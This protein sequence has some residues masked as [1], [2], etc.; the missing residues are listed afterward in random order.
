MSLPHKYHPGRLYILILLSALLLRADYDKVHD[1]LRV[2]ITTNGNN[3]YTALSNYGSL[4]EPGNRISDMVW[5]GLGYAYE[6]NM[7]VG[8]EVEVP[9]GSHPDAYEDNG[10]WKAHVFSDGVKGNGGEISP[11]GTMRWGWQPINAT[12]DGNLTLFD[13]ENPDIPRRHAYDIDGDGQTDSWPLAWESWPTLWPG[14]T[15]DLGQEYLYAM[16]D[17]DN[18]EFEYYP[19]EEDSTRRGLGVQV[20]CRTLVY[21]MDETADALVVIYDISNIS[22]RNLSRVQ[23]ALWG[24]PHIGG[25]DDWRD[26][27]IEYDAENDA[28]IVWD[29]DGHSVNSPNIIPGFMGIVFLET[30]GNA[31]DGTDNDGDGMTDESRFDGI[32]NDNDWNALYDDVGADGMEETG[33]AGESDGQPTPGEPHFDATD[34]DEGDM[35]GIQSMP[36]ISFTNIRASQDEKMWQELQPGNIES[37][38][39]PGDFVLLAGSGYFSLDAGQTKRLTAAFVFGSSREILLQKIRDLRAFY[40]R[41]IGNYLGQHSF[42]LQLEGSYPLY[43]DAI[44]LTWNI[45]E[46]AGADSL[47]LYYTTDNGKTW[48]RYPRKLYNN[49]AYTVDTEPLPSSVFYRFRLESVDGPYLYRA[50]TDSFFTVDNA[51]DENAYPEILWDL[52]DGSLLSGMDT[53]RWLDGDADGDALTRRVIIQSVLITDTLTATNHY[54]PLNTRQYPNDTYTITVK[55]SDGTAAAS[56]SRVV[57]FN[58]TFENVD[59][60]YVEHIRGPSESALWARI[61]DRSAIKKGLYLLSFDRTD[62]QTTYYSVYDSSR[63]YYL[64][65]NDPLPISP[66]SGRFFDGLS[67]S[68]ENKVYQVN[69][70]RS[71]WSENAATNLQPSLRKQ[72]DYKSLF[73]D[74][75]FLFGTGFADT[76]IN[77]INA[78]FSIRDTYSH[79]FM[80]FYMVDANNNGQWDPTETV[81]ILYGGVTIKD[82]LWEVSFYTPEGEESQ[83]PADGA[84]YTVAVD[85]P[86]S[87]EDRYIIDTNVLNL[88][89][90]SNAPG[91]FELRQNYP[92]PFN[93]STTLV[94][95]LQRGSRV[96]LDVYDIRGRLVKTLWNGYKAAGTHRL[97]FDGKGLASGIYMYRLSN[98]KQSVTRRMLLIK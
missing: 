33:D 83:L 75:E 36:I 68:C 62:D 66:K 63:G 89:S 1:E 41:R 46:T 58:N 98:G 25:P 29:D 93:P 47:A 40:A 81:F 48:H 9:E 70:E 19:F 42:A 72:D 13:P 55:V 76:S 35:V 39:T 2:T 31:N 80:D 77:G 92:N 87:A 59:T 30:P 24:D 4:S 11:D 15:D 53:L 57:E 85:K 97:R 50:L 26:D 23:C 12:N 5:K 51:P 79:Q 90:D 74:L 28:I 44:P 60:A 43:T 56:A 27:W 52:P 78:P 71:G 3:I 69:T 91:S 10:V 38:N 65:Q 14:F 61:T 21:P 64:F 20:V 18:Y 32:D 95:T 84:V 54:Y 8:A 22:S 96:S 17:R 49:G 45:T 82:I 86:F 73:H 88:A 37:Q 34:M 67:I 16:D 6:I 94:F 7:M